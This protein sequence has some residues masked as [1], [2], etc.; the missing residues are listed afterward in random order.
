[1]EGA[2][3]LSSLQRRGVQRTSTDMKD[4]VRGYPSLDSN[5]SKCKER[6][7][8]NSERSAFCRNDM[9]DRTDC[10]RMLTEAVVFGAMK[11]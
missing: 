11:L 10:E 8:S 9:H 1:M 7:L 4:L 6:E 5:F 3:L 2:A